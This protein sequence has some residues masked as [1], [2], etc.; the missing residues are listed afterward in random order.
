MR[1]I[2]SKKA[3]WTQKY[4]FPKKSKKIF[5]KKADQIL[6]SYIRR[7]NI[8]EIENERKNKEIQEKQEK[9]EQKRKKDEQKKIKKELEKKLEQQTALKLVAEKAARETEL[10]KNMHVK[11]SFNSAINKNITEQVNH[12]STRF[13]RVANVHTVNPEVFEHSFRVN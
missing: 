8:I 13:S 1:S 4:W 11:S 9:E 6:K 7:K 3:K 2:W 10:L 5:K 12:D